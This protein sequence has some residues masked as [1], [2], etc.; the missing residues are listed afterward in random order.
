VLGHLQRGG[1]P[2]AY[3]RILATRYG[4]G[5]VNLVA[6]GSFGKMVCLKGQ[7]IESVSLEAAL[8]VQNKVPV[9]GEMIQVARQL[10][11]CLGN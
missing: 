7:N 3:D 10:G 2:T 6:E 1:S 11:I 8:G 4:T 5:A 9:D